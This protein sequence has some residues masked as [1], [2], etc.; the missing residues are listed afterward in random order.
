[1]THDV[2]DSSVLV[3]QIVWADDTGRIFN[4]VKPGKFG[5]FGAL[6]KNNVWKGF[7]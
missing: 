4:S 6:R 3:R 7:V 1:M 5:H 2:Y